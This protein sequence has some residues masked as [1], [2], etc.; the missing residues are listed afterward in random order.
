MDNWGTTPQQAEAARF[1]LWVDLPIGVKSPLV[2]HTLLLLDLTVRHGH[3]EA[4]LVVGWETTP[5]PTE[6]AL[7]LLWV[8]LPLGAKS[9]L[10]AVTLRQ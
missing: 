6:A 10:D 3:G 2:M 9:Q 5:R 1:L 7:F 8:D 4:T